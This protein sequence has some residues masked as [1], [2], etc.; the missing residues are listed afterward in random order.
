MAHAASSKIVVGV[1]GSRS[2]LDALRWAIDQADVTEA[3]LY[4]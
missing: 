3:T 4:P 1:D 2:S